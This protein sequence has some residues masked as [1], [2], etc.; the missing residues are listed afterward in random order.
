MSKI[1]GS[2]QYFQIIFNPTSAAELAAMPKDLQLEILGDFKG[3]VEGRQEFSRLA[4]GR[5]SLERFRLGH[6]RIYFEPHE[7]G[8]VVHRILSRNTL[9]DFF[10]R[11]TR[12]S[13]DEDLA[14]AENPEFWRMIEEAARVSRA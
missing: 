13:K 5:K 8:V 10:F 6:Y 11:N 2:Q 4:K 7:L 14:L 3:A 9:K 12:M 1:E